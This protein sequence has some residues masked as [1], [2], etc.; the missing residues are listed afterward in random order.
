MSVQPRICRVATSWPGNFVADDLVVPLVGSADTPLSAVLGTLKQD[1]VACTY[2]GSVLTLT[3]APQTLQA[4]VTIVPSI[5]IGTA[6][7]FEVAIDTID[8]TAQT[9]L[10]RFRTPAGGNTT[11]PIISTNSRLVLAIF[12]PLPYR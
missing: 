8:L 12:R 1:L 2:L 6:A 4:G 5:E 10:V 11:P 3:F 9:I 7:L